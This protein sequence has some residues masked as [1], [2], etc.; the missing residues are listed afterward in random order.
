MS[1]QLPET[2]PPSAAVPQG[3]AE[4]YFAHVP[5]DELQEQGH[6]HAE[7]V[8][9]E[10]AGLGERRV[11][12]Q[13]L[14]RAYALEG[15]DAQLALDVV[16]DDMPFLVDS[17][18]ALVSRLGFAITWLLHPQL[19]VRRDADGR[20]QEIAG[21]AGAACPQGCAP[22]SWMHLELDGGR[23]TP[24][25]LVAAVHGVLGDV[26][27]AVEDW[28]PMRAQSLRLADELAARAP[29]GIGAA[30]AAEAVELLRWLARNSFT[31]LGYADYE[32]EP[33]GA[34]LRRVAGTELGILRPHAPASRPARAEGHVVRRFT[35]EA[36]AIAAEPR[37]LVITKA[38]SRST[39][40]R[41]AYL[42]HV[43]IKTFD[44][45]GRVVGERRFLGL[46]SSTA[47]S[48]S[49]LRIPVLRRKAEHVLQ[50][51]GTV[52]TSHS[53]RQVLQVLEAYP[54]DELF[55][56]DAPTLA[57]VVLEVL[58]L[59]ERRRV[60][61]F[62]RRD[63]YGRFVSCLLYFPRDRYTTTV[64]LRM[65]AVLR[66]AVG[67]ESVDYT[68]RVTESVLARLHFVAWVPPG[69]RLPDVD[70]AGIE[71]R[72]AAATRTWEDELTAAVTEAHSPT[73]AA[74]LLRR[75]GRAFP[76][77]Y[78]EDFG[79]AEAVLD[80]AHL[81]SLQGPEGDR[82]ALS[83]SAGAE[84]GAARLK[85]FR[86][87]PVSLSKVL[88]LLAR[89][90]VDVDDERPYEIEVADGPR[91]WVYD[92]GLRYEARLLHPGPEARAA[93]VRRFQEAFVAVWRGRADSDGFNALVLRAGLSWRQVVL[94]RAYAR[95]LRQVGLPFSQV[96][97]QQALLRNSGIAE[98]LVQLFTAR[99]DPAV[100]DG[101]EDVAEGLAARIR[102]EID[103]VEAL[104]D[105]RILR[106][107]LGVILATL[108][109]NY[110]RLDDERP[111][112]ALALKLDPRQVPDCPEPRPAFEVF[113]HSPDVEGVH[114]RFGPVARG[115]LRWSDRPEDFR[116]EVLGLVKAQAVKNSVIVPVGAKGGFV[117]RRPPA[118]AGDREAVFAEGKRCYK[119]FIGGLLDVTD[120]I[121]QAAGRSEVV[122]PPQVVRRDGDDAYLV[123]AADKGTATF[124]DLAN[125]VAADYGFW[126]GDAF[127]SGGS[128]G[129]DH[130][131]MGITARGAWE[132]VKRHFR[133]LGVDPERESVTAV[134]IGDMSGDVFGN[135][136]LLSRHLKLVAA[137]DHR[138][139][140]L[141]PDPD[142][143]VAF[144]E[145]ERLFVLPRS[146]W[147]DYDSARISAG[148]GVHPRSAKRVPVTPQVRERLGL[149]EGTTSLPPVELIRAI[150]Q[151]PVGLLWNGGIGTYVKA[152]GESAADVGD[153][154][155]D[156]V[157]IDGGQLRCQVVGEGGNLG[158]T[159]LGRIEA[160]Q[161]GV[162]L[163][164]DA[165]DNSAG[166]D[167]SDH[168]VNIKV[169][170]DAAIR[171][172][173][174][175]AQER[176][177]LLAAMEDDV[178]ALVLRENHAQNALLGM[179]RMQAASMVSVHERVIRRL[180][181]RGILDRRLERL[182]SSKEI[183]ARRA[184]GKGLTSPEYAVLVA[185]VKNT[186]NADLLATSLPD[187]PW[188]ARLLSSYFPPL[189]VERLGGRLE[190][191]PLRREIVT[192]VLVNGLV[193]RTGVSAVHRAQEET[194]APVEDV[195][196]AYVLAGE[197][198]ALGG[199]WRE[200]EALD[201]AASP[202]AQGALLLEGRR[203][204]DRAARWFLQSRPPA[205]DVEQEWGRYAP[206]VGALLPR[207]PE[208]LRGRELQRMEESTDRLARPGVPRELALRAAVLLHAFPLLDVTDVAR[209]ASYTVE[210]TADVCFTLVNRLEVDELLTAVSG[211]SRSDRWQSMARSSLRYDLYAILAALTADVLG[212]TAEG[213]AGERVQAWA[214]G[215]EA[216]LDRALGT[217]RQALALAAPDLASLSVAL[218]SLRTLLRS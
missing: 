161:A 146:S 126:L 116:T 124:S 16:T 172:G 37:V 17:L 143:A 113:V 49:V 97:V 122:P 121:V 110:F 128:A 108:R 142:P 51:A 4:A 24:E 11:P 149:P 58:R 90:G 13:T 197:T 14:A 38:N 154:A 32:L 199:F 168:E 33:D 50:A 83:F 56:V 159:Q 188:T 68:A 162:R 114:L 144:A 152:S 81:E 212:R 7:A 196:R 95:W 76:Q 166:V 20:L 88:P 210:E 156:P 43:G 112:V 8:L 55:Q 216:Q 125:G 207:V 98:L 31:F 62:V 208:L 54:R 94:L 180:E 28:Q 131:A 163:N 59:G 100:V 27:V 157:R 187:E 119:A 179:G 52:A 174:L 203:L 217:V 18:T 92:L 189:L 41:P 46:F 215:R 25:E 72:L 109:T 148:G 195:V 105:D 171:D 42:D 158:L 118:D 190:T 74:A 160:A 89:M 198:F 211:L 87:A 107:L 164:T 206:V 135:G 218:R 99:H 61:A 19:A 181:E 200:V 130:K 21:A 132:S 91:A 138:H 45:A 155:N 173:D 150:L 39:V 70:P 102:Q 184:E 35:P 134:G 29:A 133:E 64:R 139:I 84:P 175:P 205:F 192:T 182:P 145:R 186:L 137:F 147:A 96:Y 117:V 169:L 178:A 34:G 209:D 204:L 2:T 106:S 123:V 213:E 9:V 82:L 30:E 10:H 53:G 12:A 71:A 60:R 101:R 22:E 153:K 201:G 165:I 151:A 80:I 47:Y 170:I 194:G 48:E 57:S 141:D 67:A 75:Y 15:A 6:G 77:A 140:F 191:H 176:G 3:L 183:A 127:A 73:D 1:A 115:G 103:A 63:D 86:D 129:Y 23:A 214:A 79:A 177:E 93:A 78:K 193:D 85:L 69:A 65:E 111:G 5:P 136:M 40:H 66:D 104:D 26:R 120:N 185:Y 36:A 167:T 202:E 44:E